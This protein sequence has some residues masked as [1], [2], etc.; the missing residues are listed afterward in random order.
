MLAKTPGIFESDTGFHSHG[1]NQMI[2][3]KYR[4]TFCLRCLCLLI[5]VIA[6]QIQVEQK[7]KTRLCPLIIEAAVSVFRR[8]S[9][10][11]CLRWVVTAKVE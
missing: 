4:L 1:G 2:A 3:Q 7:T 9:W 6:T 5:L 11:A 8:L 10:M